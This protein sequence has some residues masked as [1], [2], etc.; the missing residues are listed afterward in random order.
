MVE[1]SIRNHHQSGLDGVMLAGNPSNMH[2]ARYGQT[3]QPWDGWAM[4]HLEYC[5]RQ[6]ETTYEIR[7]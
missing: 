4:D 3:A 2:P 5:A 7:R 1:R 6:N